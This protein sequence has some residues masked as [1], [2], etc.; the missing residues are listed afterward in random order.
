MNRTLF[1]D[2]S[3]S[4]SD[5]FYVEHSTEA[6]SPA[7]NKTAVAL[8]SADLSGAHEKEVITMSSL[9]SPEPQIVT[10]ESD[11]IE[12][13]RPYGYGRQKE[14][15]PPRH[16]DHNLPSNPFNCWLLSP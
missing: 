1:L 13:T 4:E 6:D 5:S 10:I 12:P 8:N 11:S 7:R 2:S 16:K 3:S 15:K 14:I 9:A